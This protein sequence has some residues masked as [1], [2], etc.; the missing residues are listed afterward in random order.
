M[1]AE[2]SLLQRL[3]DIPASLAS[4]QRPPLWVAATWT[5]IV[6]ANAWYLSWTVAEMVLTDSAS[7]W[8]VFMEAGSHGI[9]HG[10]YDSRYQWSPLLVPIF[11]A[12]AAIGLYWWR[13]I[14]LVAVLAMP[15]WPLRILTLASWP[16]WFDVSLGNVMIFITVLAA[17][18]LRGSR[19]AGM[20]VLASA[21]LIPRP[22]MIP[23]VVWLL[24]R[25]PPLRL[26]SVVLAGVLGL[27]T[28]GTGLAQEWVSA[29]LGLAGSGENWS[30]TL[31]GWHFNV[32]PSRLIGYWWVLFGVP[33]AALLTLRGKVGLAGLAMSPYVLPYYLLFALLDWSPRAERSPKDARLMETHDASQPKE[34]VRRRPPE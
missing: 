3:R 15:T 34:L 13:V 30:S 26:P 9:R 24:W 2:S 28:L 10:L 21:L 22:L 6:V 1:I 20:A 7:D 14:H 4:H 27:A 25:S 11:D 5:A 33:L 8:D 17:W 32:G 12:L 29:L 31:G 16:L 18:A 23:L 19:A